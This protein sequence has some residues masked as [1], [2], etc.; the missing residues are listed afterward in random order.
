MWTR[1]L[2]QVVCHSHESERSTRQLL[3]PHALL[4][5]MTR[6]P[7]IRDPEWSL[8]SQR[9]PAGAIPPKGPY[10]TTLIWIMTKLNTCYSANCTAIERRCTAWEARGH[11]GY[12]KS[13][14]QTVQTTSI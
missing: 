8:T 11:S 10:T 1:L 12:C 6:C 2:L 13:R 14:P 3:S 4:A 7:A 5:P 9:R